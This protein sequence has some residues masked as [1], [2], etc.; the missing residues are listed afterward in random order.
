MV[1]GALKSRTH[2]VGKLKEYEKAPQEKIP[3]QSV[4]HTRANKSDFWNKIETKG[5]AASPEIP[6]SDIDTTKLM[7]A[8]SI[9]LKA[10]NPLL[11]ANHQI[12]RAKLIRS[13]ACVCK[14]SKL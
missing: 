9:K 5:H 10:T 3:E 7:Q 8:P 14:K 12:L 2:S 1:R 11:Y 4:P 13:Y 6:R